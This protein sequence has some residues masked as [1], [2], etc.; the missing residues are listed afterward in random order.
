MKLSPI[1][2]IIEVEKSWLASST[3][4]EKLKAA[5]LQKYIGTNLLVIGYNSAQQNLLYKSKNWFLSSLIDERF[6]E[7]T[8]LFALA[9]T[10]EG[11]NMA[12]FF[13]D[14]NQKNVSFKL[15][16][17]LLPNWVKHVDNWAHSDS[18]SKYLTRLIEYDDTSEG[19][20]NLLS[21][22]NT[23]KNLWERRQS[24]ITLFYYARTKSKHVPFLLAKKH[25]T[26]LLSDKEYYVQK[27]V[28]WTLRESYNVYPKD[29]FQFID[30]KV[31]KIHPVAFT[32]CV[33]KMLQE[34]KNYLKAKRKKR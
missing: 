10:F 28:G 4:E 2:K 6:K 7:A 25:L 26:N 24:L 12:L 32:T 18:V 23:S 13:L 21:K 33:E 9:K 14:K 3:D 29:T 27:A 8:E 34:E 19:I 31:N 1:H 15:Q 11:K 5:K 17:K 20:L 22:W 30:S 16:L